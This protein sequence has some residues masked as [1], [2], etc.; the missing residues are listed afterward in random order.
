M[1]HKTN[2][3]YK[4]LSSPFIYSTFQKLMKGDKIR[5][6]I[7]ELSIKKKNPKILDIGCGLGDSLEYIENPVYFGYDISKTYIEYAKKKYKKKGV[8]LCRNFSQKEIKRLP[9]FDYILL[10]GILHHLTNDQILNLL[11]NIK[12]TLKKHGSLITLDPI[13]MKDQNYFARFLISHDRGKNI[14][15]K[16]E[17]LRMLKLFFKNSISRTYNQS[18][19]PYT[20]FSMSCR[21]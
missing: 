19:I 13:Y 18:F 21:N 2:K 4:I 10:I 1:S 12:K 7:L 9:K 8:F 5:K 16:K 6:K 14:K 11:S 15:T 20:W 3:F 17:Y